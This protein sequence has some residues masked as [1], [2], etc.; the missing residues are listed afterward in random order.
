MQNTDG[1]WVCNEFGYKAKSAQVPMLWV[2]NLKTE[3]VLVTYF[4]VG[5]QC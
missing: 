2:P 5:G 1:F 4:F 3:P